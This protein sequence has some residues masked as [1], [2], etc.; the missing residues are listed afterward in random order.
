MKWHERPGFSPIY[1]GICGGEIQ[2]MASS[3]DY[4][5]RKTC[6]N[7]K[8]ISEYYSITRNG[9][10]IL[11]QVDTFTGCGIAQGQGAISGR[12]GRLNG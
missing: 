2:L 6:G 3:R 4:Y 7:K 5:K 9:R 11:R 8:C 10:T 12:L 1:C